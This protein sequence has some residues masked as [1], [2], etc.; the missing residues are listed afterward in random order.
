MSPVI[1]RHQMTCGEMQFF[2]SPVNQFLPWDGSLTSASAQLVG[3]R[4]WKIFS[5]AAVRRVYCS[6]GHSSGLS[7][8]LVI[9]LERIMLRTFS[10]VILL[11]LNVG[12]LAAWSVLALWFPTDLLAQQPAPLTP[13][14]HERI[15]ERDSVEKELQ[16]FIAAGKFSEAVASAKKMFQIE[17]EALGAGHLDSFASLQ[18]IVRLSAISGDAS[19][20]KEWS[21]LALKIQQEG[22]STNHWRVQTV[23]RLSQYAG[24]C[25]QLD[26]K[27][28]SMLKEAEL[29]SAKGVQ[30][31]ES[32]K[33]Q[34]ALPH[35]T[36][37][38]EIQKDILGD[39]SPEY[40]VG[41]SN[42]GWC[43]RTLDDNEKAE[44]VLLDV[45]QKRLALL[46]PDHTDYGL[47]HNNIGWLYAARKEYAKAEFHFRQAADV[48][49]RAQG[50][51]GND[52]SQSLENLGEL[53][54][55]M[56]DFRRAEALRRQALEIRKQSLGAKHPTYGKQLR[57]LAIVY[58]FL[59]EYQKAE[60]LILEA[61]EVFRA[62]TGETGSDYA[63][64]LGN[65]AFIYERSGKP[66]EALPV[67]KQ[68]LELKIKEL[69]E[70][71]FSIGIYNHR[72]SS[73]YISLTEY[74]QALEYERKALEIF[75]QAKGKQDSNA[76]TATSNIAW[77]LGHV[78]Y[79]A[80]LRSDFTA[81][82]EATQEK[83][84]VES[85][86]YGATNWRVTNSRLSLEYLTTLEALSP[87]QRQE[88][89]TADGTRSTVDKLRESSPAEALAEAEKGL[90]IR[91]RLLGNDHWLTID[92]L[93]LVAFV[94]KEMGRYE[95]ARPV[96]MQLPQLMSK[97]R[98]EASPS[99]AIMLHNLG[100]LHL[101]MGEWEKAK[102]AFDSAL[103][104]AKQAFGER[105]QNYANTLN[106][107][108]VTNEYL[109]DYLAAE[110][111]HKQAVRIRF[112]TLGP[113]HVDYAHSLLNLG[114]FYGNS[115]GDSTK[116]EQ[117]LKEAINIYRDA[118]GEKSAFYARGIDFLATLYTNSQRYESAEPLYREALEIRRVLRG[119][120][121]FEYT[122]SLENL[123]VM[124]M[125][126]GKYAD[127]EPLLLKVLEIT[128]KLAGEESARLVISL[129]NLAYL[130]QA[131]GRRK[132]AH[133][134][135]Q[136][137]VAICREAY[138]KADPTY[139]DALGRLAISYALIG[140][141]T[142]GLPLAEE[143]LAIAHKC[144][145][146]NST[147][148][149]ERQQLAMRT[150]LW[151]HLDRYLD[152]AR[153]SNVA[154]GDMYSAVLGWKGA[155]SARQG[156][157][158]RLHRQLR[159]TGNAE[160]VR[161][162]DE[163]D[164]AVR[165][166]A[167][168]SRHSDPD[169]QERRF[170][171]EELSEKVET[172]QKEL[173]KY[174][175]ELGKQQE[176]KQRRWNDVATVL[177]DE[178]LLVDFISCQRFGAFEKGNPGKS[179]LTAYVLRKDRP[180]EYVEFGPVEP[181]ASAIEKWRTYFGQGREGQEAGHQ[182]RKLVLEPLQIHFAGAKAVLISPNGL[183]APIPWAALPGRAP[184]SYLL[185]EI[186]IATIPIPSLLPGLVE[187]KGKE[188]PPSLLLVGDVDFGGTL[189]AADPLLGSRGAVRGEEFYKWE[190]LP[191]TGREVSAINDVFNKLFG[192]QKSVT[193]TR[194]RATKGAVRVETAKHP[195][196][197]FS[198]HGFFSAPLSLDGG[199]S[200]S[201]AKGGR[202]STADVSGLHPGLLSGLVL[203][204]ANQRPEPG[205]DDGI[206]TALEVAELDLHNVELAT[207][208][209]CETGL[210]QSAGGEGL[211]GLQ[212][213]FQSAGAKTVV[214]SL[215][216]VSDSATKE[217]MVRF[218]SNLWNSERKMTKLEALR[219]AQLWMMEQGAA[220]P[221]V[222]QE[223]LGRG[224]RE[225]ESDI[226]VQTG[227]LPPYFWAA[228]VL[229]GD[230]R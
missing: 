78:S 155:V 127:A 44:P 148:Q 146:H 182:L 49:Q 159:N 71:H 221:L 55:R 46:G 111:N 30:L 58:Q 204:G 34:D 156:E 88:L 149:S 212:R 123:G 141:P 188:F 47:S 219:E 100:D 222:R 166:L 145:E 101:D 113:K 84:A 220:N 142:R 31:I 174:S 163:L 74:S 24:K 73:I 93:A 179:V 150:A 87:D 195:Y 130:N 228:F 60:P 199:G 43:Y 178:V 186:A 18:L 40:L 160:I 42:L 227:K 214:A 140:D 116:A 10:G 189:S 14:Q 59:N 107:M 3:L 176:A 95:N 184:G 62:T 83:I 110:A 210:G 124:L 17:K 122:T 209:A 225:V 125:N 70:N 164:A 6:T 99:H 152:V 230:W 170:R 1:R 194:D 191:G 5:Y 202:G 98:G 75:T 39:Q 206:L 226:V 13:H 53:Y 102:A 36:K 129:N 172:L 96:Y 165:N 180:V 215:W 213:S 90:A 77:L 20:A 69:G 190:A 128:K 168:L 45:L 81:A 115:L 196:V 229:S 126:Q 143:A 120:E 21:E 224:L 173:T 200:A 68:L 82:K 136:Q 197:H 139:A 57:L 54:V 183:T 131:T 51:L 76:A 37:A 22:R 154:S 86:L 158:R 97:A 105:D 63:D 56:R 223:V 103:K 181:I 211:L 19:A 198:T 121:S 94:Q 33:S 162:E 134:W 193:L 177:P 108:A 9:D 138:G 26:P 16:R 67:Q 25:S 133:E 208:S 29:L 15:A 187:N 7:Q 91:R 167:V 64:A 61:L 38:V 147:F 50:N 12:R 119:E 85:Q 11:I 118:S 89:D 66:R 52:Y 23:R 171:I 153:Q 135:Q 80:R 112:E 169:N 144:M 216:K 207:L 114:W 151:T 32:G 185:Q 72:I 27:Q 92:S 132:Q 137:S 201:D 217:L 175:V 218:Y 161:L 109:G 117:L 79:Q 203:T 8:A 157:I 35:L 28:L 106:S 205:Q 2:S 4:F 104:I 48:Y 65:L 41:L 192:T